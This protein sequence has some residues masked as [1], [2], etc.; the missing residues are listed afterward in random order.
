MTATVPVNTTEPVNVVE[1]VNGA[2]PMNGAVP[3]NDA[4]PVGSKLAPALTLSVVVPAFNEQEVI[5]ECLRRLVAQGDAIT[6]IVVVDNNSTDDGMQVVAQ[7]AQQYPHIRMVSE[8]TQGLVF[9][10]N[11]GLDSATGDLIARIDA[12]TRVGE[13]WASTIIEFFTADT[14]ERWA[15]LC[16]RGEA[17][18]VPFAGK[19]DKWKIRVHP[20]KQLT[21]KNR[22]VAVGD[23]PATDVAVTELPVLYGSNMILRRATWQQIRDRVSMRRTVFEDVDMGLCVQDIGGRN[24]FLSSLTVGVSPRRM[25]SGVA[26]FVR[27]MSFLPRTFALHRRYGFALGAGAVYVPALTVLHAARLVALRTY[28]VESG[29]FDPRNLLRAKPD[30]ILP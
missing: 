17:Y 24:A 2:V 14:D 23:V 4:A 11:R 20:L 30:R 8:S 25:E 10:R 22:S 7:W 28:D 15:A 5:G 19:F 29:R 6:E 13:E 9:A 18:G 12:D 1:P 3:V 26:S 21:G 16:G 27:Y